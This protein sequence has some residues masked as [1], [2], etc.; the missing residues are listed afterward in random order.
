MFCDKCGTQNPDDGKFCSKCGNELSKVDSNISKANENIKEEQHV[1]KIT[2]GFVISWIFGLFFGLVALGLFITNDYISAFLILLISVIILPPFIKLF[3]NKFNFELSR[4]LK[5]AVVFILFLM[6]VS[7]LSDATD[8]TNITPSDNSQQISAPTPIA[9]ITKNFSEIEILE[10][11][12]PRPKDVEYWTG[13]SSYG[14]ENVW[15][16]KFS[17]STEI[18]EIQLMKFSSIDEAKQ[19][20]AEKNKYLGQQA[21]LISLEYGDESFGLEAG[22]QAIIVIRKTNIV[23]TLEDSMGPFTEN[24]LNN[25]EPFAEIILEKII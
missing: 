15:N 8:Q 13:I 6:A 3:K 24:N 11:D 4:G 5:V 1:K 12:L 7:V 23:I 20:F 2:L 9:L 25:V 22:R 18:V 16:F 19:K 17:A 14:S 10:S 21:K